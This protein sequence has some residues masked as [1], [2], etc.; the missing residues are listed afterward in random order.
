[1]EKALERRTRN[2]VMAAEAPRTSAHQT[3]ADKDVNHLGR[4][5]FNNDDPAVGQQEE[6]VAFVGWNDFYNSRW[7]RPQLNRARDFNTTLTFTWYRTVGDRLQGARYRSSAPTSYRRFVRPVR[8]QK[9]PFQE[10]TISGRWLLRI[11]GQIDSP[12]SRSRRRGTVWLVPLD[13]DND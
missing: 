1:M 13:C 2:H 3:S 11:R 12:T 5:R 4:V 8:S 9:L 7:K 6:L 10:L